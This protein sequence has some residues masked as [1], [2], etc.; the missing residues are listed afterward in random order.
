[1]FCQFES[2]L[3]RYYTDTPDDYQSKLHKHTTKLPAVVNNLAF[4]FGIM[5]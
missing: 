4:A 1:M 2:I 3:M 5:I